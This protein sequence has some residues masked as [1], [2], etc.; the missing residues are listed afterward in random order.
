MQSALLAGPE[1]EA[2]G[3][4]DDR[5]KADDAPQRER[6][7]ANA[8]ARERLE[9]TISVAPAGR[10]FWRR[11]RIRASRWL[12]DLPRCIRTAVE[13]EEAYGHIFLLYPV[14][15]ICGTVWWFCNR[16]DPPSTL[17]IA[18]AVV[19]A[20]LL[21]ATRH[22]DKTTRVPVRLAAFFIAGAVAASLQTARTATV[23]IDSPVTTTVTARVIDVEM[24]EAG[25]WRYT[26]AIVATERPR[27]KRPPTTALLGLKGEDAAFPPGTI[28][29]GLARLQ[30]PAGPA[31]PGLNDFAF[32]S[33]FKGIG[34]I[35]GFMGRPKQVSIAGGTP[36]S[37]RMF[38]EDRLSSI[39]GAI[40]QR[41]LSVLPGDTGAFA[42]A[43]VTNDTAAF[44]KDALEALRISGLAHVISISGLHMV[45]AAGISFVGLRMLF[46]LFPDFIQKRPAKTY[47]ALGAIITSGLYLLI[48]GMPVSAVRSFI[49]LAVVMGGVMVS[50]TVFTLRS[51]ALAAFVI[52]VV[53]PASVLGPSFQMSFGAATALVSGYSLWR[54]R[55]VE[56]RRFSGLPFYK[57]VLP[58]V[59]AV[60]GVML[61]S[62]IAGLATAIFSVTHFH[63]LTLLGTLGNVAAMP[64]ISLVVMPAGFLAVLLMPF[65]LDYIPLRI[66]GLGLDATLA[67]A[68][69][70]SSLGGDI[71][72]GR[73]AGWVLPAAS[74]AFL[75]AILPRT[76]FFRLCGAF[77]F[78]LVLAGVAAFGFARRPAMVVSETADLV[79]IVSQGGIATNAARP[80][81]FIMD[82]WVRALAMPGT[83]KPT[84]AAP[85]QLE[86]GEKRKPL[87]DRDEWQTEDA[88]QAAAEA[89]E[90]GHFLCSGRDW[91]IGRLGNN[92]LVAT[93]SD[94]AFQGPACRQA[95]IVIAAAY[96]KQPQCG[97]GE[98]QLFDRNA[99]RQRG[100]LAVY[101]AA[102]QAPG[103][104]PLSPAPSIEIIG[105]LD[106]LDRPW[107]R[108][109]FYDWRS[110][111]YHHAAA[112]SGSGE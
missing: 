49:M 70:V 2:L 96:L 11:F 10:D 54:L 102:P 41:I 107:L 71:V 55:P 51:V 5:L 32:D 66:M 74:A 18:W 112:V 97:D 60:G 24:R 28:L 82:Q 99:L 94:F 68:R 98:A 20:P 15:M 47:A 44:S 62:E 76:R 103:A 101:L 31:L 42:S 83:I 80:S 64:F 59:K 7:E 89:V 50:R 69:Y 79:G 6:S 36:D 111:A 77:S 4:L 57:V 86:R 25:R 23:I 108:H 100:A 45:L 26:V 58:A 56:F 75:M 63:R 43:L 73:M 87:T 91:C 46:S 38:L 104:Q 67:V 81:V 9:E 14:F 40:N 8:F 39:R 16:T 34:A 19:L 109:R 105:A 21:F 72:T 65:G 37:L 33:Y 48:S 88:M 106:G 90:P 61:T 30:P 22:R 3:V 95:S 85:L 84:I 35:G 1:T 29:K 92:V 78:L 12:R 13:E 110:N 52:L 93:F 53:T 17:L 27:L